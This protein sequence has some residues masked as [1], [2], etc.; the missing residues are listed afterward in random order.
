[1]LRAVVLAAGE[2][3]RMGRPKCGLRLQPDGPTFAQ[4]IVGALHGAGLT[5]VTIVAGAHP[6]AVRDSVPGLSDVQVIDNPGWAAGQLSSL[7]AGLDAVDAPEVEGVL[8]TLVDCPLVTVAT[9]RTLVAH[10]SAT[11]A[12]VVRPSQGPRHGHPVIF[13]R[14]TFAALR[15]APR[16]IGAKAVIAALGGR[17]ANV[18][19]DD[20]GIFVD[21]DT[22]ERYDEVVRDRART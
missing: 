20:S 13:D 21:I 2:S 11:R 8:V 14:E 1:M 16:E 4:A 17:V 5:P 9:I 19:V 3:R 12:P 6:A 15:T 18:E 7:V 22:P 10:W